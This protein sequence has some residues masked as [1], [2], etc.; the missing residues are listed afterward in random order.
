MENKIITEMNDLTE[1]PK[2]KQSEVSEHVEK[3]RKGASIQQFDRYRK[4]HASTYVIR[5]VLWN[6]RSRDQ[7]KDRNNGEEGIR[8]RGKEGKDK[9]RNAMPEKSK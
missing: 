1:I 2:N 8:L 9:Q 6:G 5:S 3:S 4:M 7:I